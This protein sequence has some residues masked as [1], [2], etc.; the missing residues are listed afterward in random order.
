MGGVN[1]GEAD[2]CGGDG[3]PTATLLLDDDPSSDAALDVAPEST[4]VLVVS[5]SRSMREVVEE[6]RRRAGTL[7]AAL[8]VITYAEFDRS[9][10]AAPSGTPSRKPLS[11]G[12]ITVTSMSDPADLRRLGTAVTLY[13]DDWVDTDRETL[14]YVDALDPFVDANGVESTFQFLHLLV[15]SVDQSAADVV[16]RLDPSTTDE[17][18][19]NTYRPL[20]GRV[21]DATTTRTL[22]DDELHALLANGRRRFV[23]RSLL[24]QPTLELDRLATRLARWENDIDEP[25][26]TQH[27]R[28]Y[29]ALASVHLPRLTEAGIVTFDRSAERVRLADGNWSADRLRR[30]LTAPLDDDG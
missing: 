20:F 9:A 12:D 27:T 15:Q 21:V 13:L 24:D 4:N 14:V 11:G 8:G 23:L 3:R 29:T 28:A 1:G 22:D 25:T 26:D 17:R 18:T 19:I 30:Y 2:A 5:A 10:S 6:W 16:V 7:P